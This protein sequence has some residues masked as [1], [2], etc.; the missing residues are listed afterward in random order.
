M[1]N[2]RHDY[3]GEWQA[4]RP[5]GRTKKSVKLLLLDASKCEQSEDWRRWEAAWEGQGVWSGQLSMIEF[6]VNYGS[7]ACG[8]NTYKVRNTHTLTHTRL[9][10]RPWQL[11]NEKAWH[12]RWLC[13]ATS[14]QDQTSRN[15]AMFN[16][17]PVGWLGEFVGVMGSSA[18][19]RACHALD[20]LHFICF[21]FASIS[22]FLVFR[23]LPYFSPCFLLTQSSLTIYVTDDSKRG[24][25]KW[26]EICVT[27]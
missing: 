5:A 19:R 8:T 21:H 15:V 2:I 23:L 3:P 18:D 10:C 13:A 1:P 9:C 26:N 27:L 25:N 24:V 7:L 12:V 14:C 16:C 22:V 4:G 20:V 17:R 11:T 6:S